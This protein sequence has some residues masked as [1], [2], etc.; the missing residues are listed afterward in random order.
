MTADLIYTEPHTVYVEK[1]Q[2]VS[3]QKFYTKEAAIEAASKCNCMVIKEQG[4]EIYYVFPNIPTTFIAI[5]M[6]GD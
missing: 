5:S 6:E 4:K 2:T 3:I 1:S